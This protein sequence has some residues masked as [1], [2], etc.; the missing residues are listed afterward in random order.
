MIVAKG[1]DWYVEGL[2][3]SAHPS[4]LPCAIVV[5]LHPDLHTMIFPQVLPAADHILEIEYNV[6]NQV[7]VHIAPA[8]IMR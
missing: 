4:C 7:D 5:D 8:R 6:P 1:E 2:P 3:D